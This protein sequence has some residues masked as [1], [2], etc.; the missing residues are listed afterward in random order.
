MRR[1]DI[2]A[3]DWS[4]FDLVYLFQRPESMARAAEKAQRELRPGAWMVSLE[5]DAAALAPTKVL[6]CAD[7]RRASLYQVPFRGRG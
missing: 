5:F 4:G 7:G 6:E 3:A 1:A 2:W